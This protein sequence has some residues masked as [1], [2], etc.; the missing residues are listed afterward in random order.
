MQYEKR[1]VTFAV[2]TD[3]YLAADKSSSV[4]YSS[5]YETLST[6]EASK[7]YRFLATLF[8]GIP[9]FGYYILK[10]DGALVSLFYSQY[11]LTQHLQTGHGTAVYRHVF[12]FSFF[13][14]ISSWV[15]GIEDACYDRGA[16]PSF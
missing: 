9:F 16:P 13:I 6:I 11:L 2:E 15:G 7:V 14:K 1:F 12:F 5:T 3:T 10:N 4:Q 8:Q